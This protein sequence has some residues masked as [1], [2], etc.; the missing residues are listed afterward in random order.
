M[1]SDFLSWKEKAKALFFME[2]MSIAEISK[3]IGISRK[4]ITNYLKLQP[5][6]RNERERRKSENQENRKKYIKQWSKTKRYEVIDGET[7]K[8]EHDLAAYILSRE[9]H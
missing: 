2:K 4:S 8:R 1:G 9:R 6:Y 5:N 7:L 3:R